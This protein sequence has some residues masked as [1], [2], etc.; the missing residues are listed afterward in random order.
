MGL[1]R[2]VVAACLQVSGL[3]VG[4][5]SLGSVSVP[6]GGGLLA[7]GLVVFGLAVERGN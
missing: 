2:P 1:R 4:V 7:V 3:L 6:A 5:V